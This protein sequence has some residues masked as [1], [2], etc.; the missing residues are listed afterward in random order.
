MK[1]DQ[2][3]MKEKKDVEKELTRLMELTLFLEN[4]LYCATEAK[5]C[6]NN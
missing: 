4:E 2:I 5:M 6:I 1:K 3:K